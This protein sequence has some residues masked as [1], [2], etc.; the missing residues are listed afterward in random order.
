MA[1]KYY[2]R[3]TKNPKTGKD[4]YV[5]QS[6]IDEQ[7]SQQTV[8]DRIV[9]KSALS[10]GDIMSCITE[11]FKEVTAELLE[12]HSVKL[13]NFGSFSLTVQS[14]SQDAEEKVTADCIES[15]RIVFRPSVRWYE[16]IKPRARY[17]KVAKPEKK[18]AA[19]KDEESTPST[20]GGTGSGG[21]IDE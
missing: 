10:E 3:Q 17:M 2:V 12:G 13:D 16:T 20:G 4:C 9:E 19:N 15:C 6:L 21:G 5:A 18:N 11:L 7:V 8:I 14:K 1:I